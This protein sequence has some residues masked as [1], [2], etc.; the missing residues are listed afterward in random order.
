MITPPA[1]TTGIA[2]IAG[3]MMIVVGVVG[4]IGA[5]TGFAFAHP[6]IAPVAL[7]ANFAASVL[8][9]GLGIGVLRHNRAAWAFAVSMF[10]TMLCVN[11]LALPQFLRADSVGT[12]STLLAAMRVVWGVM[13]I[14]GRKEF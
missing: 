6:K 9:I 14:H 12:A 1:K 8:D 10:G 4:V 11:L 7:Y 2:R 13:L 5:V 3:S